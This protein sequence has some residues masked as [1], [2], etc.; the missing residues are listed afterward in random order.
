MG[1]QSNSLEDDSIGFQK[2]PLCQMKAGFNHSQSCLANTAIK[3]SNDF[4]VQALIAKH[5]S[6]D[7]L[8]FL[9]LCNSGNGTPCLV[10]YQRRDSLKNHVLSQN[11]R[12]LGL[13][14]YYVRPDFFRLALRAIK[15]MSSFRPSS[16]RTPLLNKT[17]GPL[18]MRTQLSPTTV[19]AANTLLHL[20]R[21]RLPLLLDLPL[22]ALRR[23]PS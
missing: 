1:H 20:L 19:S 16:G 8:G 21:N 13:A 9:C 7:A 10:V 23:L 2:C 6:K 11:R 15:L 22:P 4:T 12:W 17:R 18:W 14:G 5:A 3:L